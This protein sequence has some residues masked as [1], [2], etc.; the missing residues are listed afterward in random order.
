MIKL[1]GKA[2]ENHDQ[3]WRPRVRFEYSTSEK[4][5]D[6]G[7]WKLI[8]GSMLPDCIGYY[9]ELILNK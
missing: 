6:A 8:N 7:Y 1:T 4:I 5:I 3:Y 2:L 9:E